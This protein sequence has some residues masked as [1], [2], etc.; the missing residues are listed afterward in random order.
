MAHKTSADY[1]DA[2]NGVI[3]H[4][5][6][7]ANFEYLRNPSQSKPWLMIDKLMGTGK[8][9]KRW[10]A[11]GG[12]QIEVDV[13]Y[14]DNGTA[15]FVYPDQTYTLTSRDFTA[16]ATIPW[17]HINAFY[18]V[19][20]EEIRICRAPE[21]LYDSVI[22]PKRLGTQMNM[23]E[24]IESETFAASDGTSGLAPLTMPY[25][26]VPITG[27]QVTALTRT[28]QGAGTAYGTASTTVGGLSTSTYTRWKNYNDVRATSDGSWTDADNDRFCWMFDDMQFKAPQNVEMLKD[29]PFNMLGVYTDRTTKTSLERRALQQNDNVG[30]DVARYHGG[31]FIKNI[32]I[33]HVRAL[34]TASAT[35]R[36]TYPLYL[37]N[38]AYGA[39]VIREGNFFREEAFPGTGEAPNLTV[40]HID[41]SYNLLVTNRMLFGGVISYVAAG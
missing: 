39:P 37:M 1:A 13:V 41:L 20:R 28:F 15:A 17:R 6:L 35:A 38:W 14:Q 16:K 10:R 12:S 22:A 21:K 8:N 4:R 32:P 3:N 18:T 23:A 26:V 2:V 30:P 33:E 29:S 25:W 31:T 7:G 36:G 11:Q 34:D 40:V 9:A 5:P 24:V 19:G 27:A